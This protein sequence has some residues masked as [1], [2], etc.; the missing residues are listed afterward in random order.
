[1][2]FYVRISNE[3]DS[4]TVTT[5]PSHEV[6]KLTNENAHHYQVHSEHRCLLYNL[7]KWSASAG[8]GK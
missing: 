2:G 4:V 7:V 3:H 1:M 8:I 5:L 6:H